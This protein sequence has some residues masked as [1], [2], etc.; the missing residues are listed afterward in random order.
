M[1]GN[2]SA[3][4]SNIAFSNAKHAAGLQAVSEPKPEWCANC[5]NSF[6]KLLGYSCR[7]VASLK[8]DGKFHSA[9]SFASLP[10]CLPERKHIQ[11]KASDI[12]IGG[13]ARSV[14]MTVTKDVFIL[15][16]FLIE[17]IHVVHKEV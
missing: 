13:A 15:Q 1:A 16:F 9:S 4:F 12:F 5:L 14:I 6:W 11:E 8:N 10:K 17:Y 3:A 2:H 7:S